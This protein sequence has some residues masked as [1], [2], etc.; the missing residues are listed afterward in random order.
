MA[1]YLPHKNGPTRL[2]PRHKVA[3][4]RDF[5]QI[6]ARPNLTNIVLNCESSLKQT[7]P[8]K[9]QSSIGHKCK[10]NDLFII[11]VTLYSWHFQFHSVNVSILHL[12]YEYRARSESHFACYSHCYITWCPLTTGIVA[13]QF[14]SSRDAALVT[15]YITP[16]MSACLDL[17]KRFLPQYSGLPNRSVCMLIYLAFFTTLNASY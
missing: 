6:K 16:F 15:C 9:T 14:P 10:D 3:D 7:V 17:L 4:C 5:C 8:L 2:K 11:P 12:K 13:S 1:E